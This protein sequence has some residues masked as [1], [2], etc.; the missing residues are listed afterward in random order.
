MR[1][2]RARGFKTFPG[3][4]LSRPFPWVA[5]IFTLVELLVVVSVIAI[6]ASLLLPALKLCKEKSKEILCVSNLRQIGCALTLYAQDNNGWIPCA[7]D[8]NN[9]YWHQYLSEANYV[10]VPSSNK[11]SVLACPSFYPNGLYVGVLSTYGMRCPFNN[12]IWGLN[13]FTTP[14]TSDYTG[15]WNSD[16]K[17]SASN[18]I[19]VAD[20]AETFSG[21]VWAQNY[22]FQTHT[23]TSVPKIHTRHSGKANSLFADGHVVGCQTTDLEKAGIVHYYDKNNISR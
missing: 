19:I 17:T 15:G 18:C 9:K 5:K 4:G 23:A 6:L 10:P 7:K 13:I 11:S 3:R 8:A 20:T 22:G 14:V 2:K 21:V 16:W 12:T 1:L